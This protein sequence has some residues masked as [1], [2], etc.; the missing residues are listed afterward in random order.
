MNF[1]IQNLNNL[2]FQ[3]SKKNSVNI[4]FDYIIVKDIYLFI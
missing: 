2:N 4:L 1:L 3:L